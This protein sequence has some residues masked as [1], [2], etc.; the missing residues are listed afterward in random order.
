MTGKTSAPCMKKQDV[1]TAHLLTQPTQQ[2]TITHPFH[3]LYSRTFKII[4]CQRLQGRNYFVF[5]DH[6][7]KKSIVPIAWTDAS[8][9]EDAFV[10]VS[11]GRSYFRVQDLLRLSDLVRNLQP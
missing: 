8:K 2:F 11:A 4:K 5:I 10:I 7:G 9:E 1:H 6:N 3:P